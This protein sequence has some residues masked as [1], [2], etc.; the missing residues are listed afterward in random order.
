MSSAAKYLKEMEPHEVVAKANG[1]PA[2]IVCGLKTDITG[3][4][5]GPE[6]LKWIAAGVKPSSLGEIAAFMDHI[7]DPLVDCSH[8]VS[9]RHMPNPFSRATNKAVLQYEAGLPGVTSMWR[10]RTCT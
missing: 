10:L 3:E 2:F 1:L 7:E 8:C 4:P 9:V 6:Y 5:F